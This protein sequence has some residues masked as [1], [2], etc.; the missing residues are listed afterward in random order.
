MK[1]ALN[2]DNDGLDNAYEGAGDEGVTPV[3]FDN[4]G[5]PD[6][7]DLDSD[8][9]GVVDAIEGNDINNDGI[10]DLVVVGDWMPISILIGEGDNKFSNQTTNY[11]LGK[12]S[13]FWR[14]TATFPPVS[15]H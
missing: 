10:M 6:Y 4:E 7:L 1:F 9:D 8:N 3:N 15:N 2:D 5:N 11:N 14:G 13:G 12:S